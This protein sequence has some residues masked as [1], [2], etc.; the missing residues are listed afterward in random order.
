MQKKINKR[1]QKHTNNN[2]RKVHV[3]VYVCV[4]VRVSVWCVGAWVC[5]CLGVVVF[6]FFFFLMFPVCLCFFFK[7]KNSTV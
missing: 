2:L 4:W 7:K 1:E 5:G 3:T 6:F